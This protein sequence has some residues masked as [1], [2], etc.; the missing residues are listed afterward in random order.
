MTT[1]WACHSGRIMVLTTILCC[2]RGQVMESVKIY[3]H[4]QCFDSKMVQLIQWKCLSIGL[5]LVTKKSTFK[6]KKKKKKRIFNDSYRLQIVQS[7]FHVDSARL[8]NYAPTNVQCAPTLTLA[9]KAI[10]E[11]CKSLPIQSPSYQIR[12]KSIQRFILKIC[13]KSQTSK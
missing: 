12:S 8:W 10:K 5:S 3:C 11:Y 4:L 7:S 13:Y 6:K 2:T 9:K 1:R